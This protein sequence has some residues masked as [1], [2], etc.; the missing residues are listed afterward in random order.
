MNHRSLLLS[1]VVSLATALPCFAAGTAKSGPQVGEKVPGPFHPLNINGP[2]AGQKHCLYCENGM[3]PTV[4]IFAVR[5]SA[6]VVR[7]L[8]SI[9]AVAANSQK[10][11]GVCVIFCSDD[12]NMAGQLQQMAKDAGL[13][14]TVVALFHADGPKEYR[15]AADAEATVLLYNRVVVQANH[16]FKAGELTDPA[17]TAVLVDLPTILTGD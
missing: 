7:L 12:A 16:A 9:E 2:F 10:P 17:I 4:M 6:G 3:K 5:P 13:S 1:I 8:Q 15:L 14:R 11:F